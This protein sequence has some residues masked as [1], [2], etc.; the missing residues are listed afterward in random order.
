MSLF[1][2]QE[3]CQSLDHVALRKPPSA[4]VASSSRSAPLAGWNPS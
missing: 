2:W 4:S 1:W 3:P